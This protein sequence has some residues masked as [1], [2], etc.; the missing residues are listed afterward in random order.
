MRRFQSL[1]V[2]YARTVLTRSQ[3]LPLVRVSEAKFYLRKLFY[4]GVAMGWP[5]WAWPPLK[6]Y[7]PSADHVTVKRQSIITNLL[8]PVHSST[9]VSFF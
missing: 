1:Y 6:D 5:G 7:G 8:A 4:I 9:Q 3:P 2:V